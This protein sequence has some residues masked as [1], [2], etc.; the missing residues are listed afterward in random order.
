MAVGPVEPAAFERD[1]H[2]GIHFMH[3]LGAALRA[4]LDRIVAERLLLREVI[5]A[6]LAAVVIDRHSRLLTPNEYRSRSDIS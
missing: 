3:L 2:S 5:P 1:R 4:Y 6:L